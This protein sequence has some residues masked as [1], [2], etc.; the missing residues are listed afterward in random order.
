VEDTATATALGWGDGIPDVAVTVTPQ[1][2][3]S[4]PQQFQGSAAG[5]VTLNQIAGGKYVVDGVRW[6]TDAERAQLPAGDDAVGFVARLPL[7]T[8]AGTTQLPLAM[9][10]SRRKGIVISEFKG[11]P[12]EFL[13]APEA[14]FFSGYLRL[15][16]NGDTTAYLDG[17]IVGAGLAAQYAYPN[18]PCSLY[19]PYAL[20]PSGVWSAQFVQLPGGGTDHPLAPGETAVLAT[21]AIDH[22]PLYPIGLDLRN[23]D[24]EFYA[25]ASDI[26]NPAVP[27]ATDLSIWP[28]PLGHG[29]VWSSLGKVVFV[30][31]PFDVHSMHTET[32]GNATMG[33][34][35][36]NALLDVMAIK[37]AWSGS[38][39]PECPALVNPTFDREAVQLLG[40]PFRDDTLA[41]RRRIV[42]F[43][44]GGQ[45]VL[46]HTR[47]S[48]W[49]VGVAPRN[50]FAT[51]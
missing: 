23:A 1:D 2:S 10:A 31:W 48:A 37:T 34:I 18:F 25:G 30:A 6:L 50:P 29:L 5:D 13:G 24:F 14:Y 21:D 33:R 3:S 17:L 7:N 15:Y 16:N 11:D 46:Q 38:E 45:A 19:Q 49:D 4:P 39:Y 40:E 28:N 36:A 44:I 47:T 22:R 43:T 51:P 8:A 35:P 20:D 12:I 41:Y 26:D 9:V 42:P 27:N 32:F